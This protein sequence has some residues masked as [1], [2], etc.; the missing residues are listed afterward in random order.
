MSQANKISR[1]Y[2][3][4]LDAL[5]HHR[6]K[7]Q[8]KITVEHVHIHSGGQAVVGVV[9]P[10]GGV[11]PK[12]EDQAHAPENAQ[13]ALSSPDTSATERTLTPLTRESGLRGIISQ[14]VRIRDIPAGRRSRGNSVVPSSHAA[15]FCSVAAAGSARGAMRATPALAFS[16]PRLSRKRARRRMPPACRPRFPGLRGRTTRDTASMLRTRCEATHSRTRARRTCRRKPLR[17]A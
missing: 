1:T 2:A 3:V 12:S 8:Q 11:Q 4:L 14:C 10:R 17:F 15:G 6:G 7:G 9:A 5:N 16:G 13:L